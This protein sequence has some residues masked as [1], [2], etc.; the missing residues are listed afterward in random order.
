MHLSRNFVTFSPKFLSFN[1]KN[2]LLFFFHNS[3]KRYHEQNH[4][5]IEG[6]SSTLLAT[7]SKL[8]RPDVFVRY[9]FATFINRPQLILI[10]SKDYLILVQDD[11][12]CSKSHSHL[13]KYLSMFLLS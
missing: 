8:H 7:I 10:K 11:F 9:L 3:Q 1:P 5:V 13:A 6:K 2:M 12:L 4:H